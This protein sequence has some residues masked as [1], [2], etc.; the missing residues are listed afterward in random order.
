[1]DESVLL[2]PLAAPGH[3]RREGGE[4][5]GPKFDGRSKFVTRML[6]EYVLTYLAPHL[7]LKLRDCGQVLCFNL[8]SA[9]LKK[10]VTR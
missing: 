9:W 3:F 8:R 10:Y 2:G 5:S 7:S 4:Y 6:I 1:M